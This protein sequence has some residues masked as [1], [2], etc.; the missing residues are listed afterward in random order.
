MFIMEFVATTAVMFL[1]FSGYIFE[2]NR[3]MH[4]LLYLE[5]RFVYLC[6]RY[7]F[8]YFTGFSRIYRHGC[9][10]QNVCCVVDVPLSS[11]SSPVTRP[12]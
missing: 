2:S 7:D 10:I 3:M 12:A 8:V 1:S 6:N 11:S 5:I 9:N 4:K